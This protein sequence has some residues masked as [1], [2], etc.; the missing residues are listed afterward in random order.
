MPYLRMDAGAVESMLA[1]SRQANAAMR[2]DTEILAANV[3]ATLP[4]WN[5]GAG[6]VF[7]QVNHAFRV[8]EDS[9]NS[10]HSDLTGRGEQA[11]AENLACVQRC[12]A[13]FG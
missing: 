5:D 6:E 11:V 3:N 2:E 12:A 13:R 1:G 8:H 4:D 9:N 10:T 7:G